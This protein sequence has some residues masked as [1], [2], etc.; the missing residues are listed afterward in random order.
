[1]T[2]VSDL[3]AVA[4]CSAT[5]CTYNHDGCH[6]GAIT[7]ASGAACATFF[8]TGTQGG[9]PKVVATV[10]ACQRTTCL[11]NENAV[12]HADSV[13]IGPGAGAGT[14]NCLTFTD[15]S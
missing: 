9:L 2:T 1:M 15:K 14:A 13:R 3:P 5:E 4:D 11:H 8:E 10:G 6:A 7:V 12:C